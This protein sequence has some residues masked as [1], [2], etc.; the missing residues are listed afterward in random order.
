VKTLLLAL[1]ILAAAAP[2]RAQDDAEGSKD[3]PMFSRM[4]GYFISEY[5]AQ[6]FSRFDFPTVPDSTRVEG[7]Y[8]DIN[9]QIKEGAKRVG[10][11]RSAATTPT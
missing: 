5:D 8:W 4:P 6:D 10:P 3:H 1:A 11:C 2:V 9:Y 7:R